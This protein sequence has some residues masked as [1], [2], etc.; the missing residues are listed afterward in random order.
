VFIMDVFASPL[1]LTKYHVPTSR[2]QIVPRTHLVERLTLVVG[3]ALVLVCAPAGYGKTTLLGECAQSLL[4]NGVAVAWYALD[5]SDDDPIPFS[6]Y[7]VASLVQALGPIHELVR[8]TQLVHS[9]PDLDLQKILPSIINAIVSSDRECVM[10]L[11]DYHLIGAPA[12][13][14]A[15]SFFLEH[16]PEKMHSGS[17]AGSRKTARDARRRSALLTG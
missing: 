3:N 17:P 2:P 13:H 10:F 4:K 5:P 7:L 11:D 14:N 9:T 6:A 12:I 16:L 1:I 15:L 8:I